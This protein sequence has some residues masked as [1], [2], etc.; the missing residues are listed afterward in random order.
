MPNTHPTRQRARRWKI[1]EGS[2]ESAPLKT[3]FYAESNVGGFS[4]SD[5]GVAFFSQLAAVLR[6]TDR[7]LDFGAGRGE[8]ILDDP[9]PYR[10]ELS[11]L[12]GRC[13]HVEGCDVDDAVLTNPFLDH[14]EVI[15]LDEP[16][17]YDDNSFDLVFSRFVFE[18]VQN[19]DAVAQELIRVVKPGG[20]IA[21]MTPN[22]HGY[23]AWGG[24]LVPNR[25][26]VRALSYVQPKRKSVDVFPTAYKM[27]T[28][29]ELRDLFGH[30]ADVF[31]VYLSSEPAYFFG[32][33][34]I[35]RM[36]KFAH[37]YLPD[38]LRPLLTVYIRKR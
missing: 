38:R 26:H 30:A 11:T 4:Y 8:Y 34:T 7:V 29:R 20:L 13:A 36:G 33:A 35:Y 31:T 28:A 1:S 9:I 12:R 10:R 22:K 6:P 2:A 14:A 32:R 24:W 5:A 23:I 37:K 19:P 15:R 27:N 21:A 16:L 18:H 3:R 17:P 25:W